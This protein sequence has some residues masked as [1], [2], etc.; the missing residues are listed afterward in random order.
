MGPR[1]TRAGPRYEGVRPHHGSRDGSQG[2]TDEQDSA[3][4][5][6][7]ATFQ[8][9]GTAA[10]CRQ[11]YSAT[12]IL[13]LSRVSL[14]L[15]PLRKPQTQTSAFEM[16]A[17]DR[18]LW[19]I[20][21]LAGLLIFWSLSGR[22]LWQDEAET[23]LLGQNILKFAVPKAYD[24]TN[25]V[26]QEAGREFNTKVYVWRWSPW[27]QYYLA[28]MSIG[29]FGPSTLAARLPFAILGFLTVPATY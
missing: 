23:A 1:G 12:L 16:I 13:L 5:L 11:T 21:A 20:V 29:I 25:I 24:G 14:M 8:V 18:V 28:A 9:E 10:S 3:T 15:E 22:Y 17:Q 6:P 19:A 27:L 7:A 4:D 26:S 2:R